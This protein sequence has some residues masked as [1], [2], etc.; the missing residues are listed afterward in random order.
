MRVGEGLEQSGAAG[1]DAVVRLAEFC[2][3]VA[4]ALRRFPLRLGALVRVVAPALV[5]CALDEREA[6]FGRQRGRYFAAPSVQRGVHEG[7]L[8]H[9]LPLQDAHAHVGHAPAHALRAHALV[10]VRALRVVA[11]PDFQTSKHLEL[12]LFSHPDGVQIRLDI[13]V[14]ELQPLQARLGVSHGNLLQARFFDGHGQLR[15]EPFPLLLQRFRPTRF[16][17]RIF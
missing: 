13:L 4:D 11:P 5:L 17:V 16:D 7:L 12:L 14:L 2:Q 15:P 8:G 6:D 10:A 3:R 1:D 9:V